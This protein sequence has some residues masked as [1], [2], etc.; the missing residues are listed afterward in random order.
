MSRWLVLVVVLAVLSAGV[1]LVVWA[2]RADWL[3][4]QV[5]VHWGL[6]GT[7][8]G[9]VPREQ[10][11]WWL[12]IVPLLLAG[13][14]VLAALLPWLSPVHFKVQPFRSTY[15][16][17]VG[18]IGLL[19]A[20]L[21]GVILSAQVGWITGDN[22]PRWLVGGMLLI[23]ALLGNVLGK[24]K[25]NFWVG[26][27]T[28]WTL[29]SDVVWDRTHRLAAWLFVAGGLVGVLMVLVGLHPLI[30]FAPFVVAALFPVF[31]SLWLYK[32]LEKQGRLGG[33][34]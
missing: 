8:D 17:I 15:D 27:R 4:E 11:F 24:V 28:P 16:Y 22:L 18:L 7:A 30:A 25:R 10:A 19:F 12:M 5:P 14:A 21:G 32:R 29:A 31:Y 9:F 26:V 34:G 13:W 2:N 1:T 20:Y 23:F 3:P 6:K 33:D